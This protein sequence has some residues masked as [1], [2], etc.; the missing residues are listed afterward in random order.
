MFDDGAGT[1]NYPYPTLAAGAA[2]PNTPAIS[3]IFH[4]CLSASETNTAIA[5]NG[6][7]LRAGATLATVSAT[8]FQK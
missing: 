8:G 3:V 5:V 6:P 7:A 2:V 4:P 1:L